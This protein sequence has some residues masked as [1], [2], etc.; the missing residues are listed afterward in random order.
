MFAEYPSLPWEFIVASELTR[1]GQLKLTL[2]MA[3]TQHDNS[4]LTQQ[5]QALGGHECSYAKPHAHQGLAANLGVLK[6]HTNNWR[7]IIG[8]VDAPYIVRSLPFEL[9]TFGRL[10]YCSNL[11]L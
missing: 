7:C 1:N 9:V 8:V 5:M 11:E 3:K 10:L 4:T 6:V 2:D